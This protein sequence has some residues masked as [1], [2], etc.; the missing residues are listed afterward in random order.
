MSTLHDS[1][2]PFIAIVKTG[3]LLTRDGANPIARHSSGVAGG[4]KRT[5]GDSAD[6]HPQIVIFVFVA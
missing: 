1:L 2:Y 4:G 5:G 6:A 3:V